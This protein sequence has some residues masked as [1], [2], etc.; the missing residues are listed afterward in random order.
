MTSKRDDPSE[1]KDEATRSALHRQVVR[2]R[3]MV[4]SAVE[5]HE[6]GDV[7]TGAEG[8][9]VGVGCGETINGQPVQP[10]DAVAASTMPDARRPR[11]VLKPALMVSVLVVLI[12]ES[13]LMRPHWYSA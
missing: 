13:M 3:L 4:E 5:R 8:K 7:E 9:G 1:P 11:R 2:S 10:I 12:A 6:R